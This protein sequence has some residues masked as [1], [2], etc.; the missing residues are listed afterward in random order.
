M[1]T[2]SLQDFK[3]LA[4]RCNVIPLSRET[5]VD[6]VTPVSVYERLSRGED[7]SYLLESVEGGERFGRYSFV[8]TRPHALFT[9]RE[10][11]L[12]FKEGPRSRSWT[13]SNPVQDMKKLFSQYRAPDL[14]ELPLF[15]GGAVGYW[16]YDTVRFFERLP[17]K[18][19]DILGFP[20]GAFQFS[21][22]L[23]IFDRL[24]QTAR[25]MTNVFIPEKRPS[26]QTLER[27]Y[28]EGLR[29][30][31]RQMKR[32]HD[33]SDPR[34]T[35]RPSK[36]GA[37]KPLGSRNDYETAVRKAKEYI[38]AGDIIQ[39]VLSQRWKIEPSAPPFEVYRALRTV[40]P[41][42]YMY[43]LH[44]PDFDIVGSSPEILVRKEGNQAVTRPIAGTRHRGASPE[45]DAGL[46]EELLKD[47]KERAEHL[48]L[49]DLGR[50]DLGRVCEPGSVR[51]PE[52]M[53]IE[54]YSH[55][56]HLV[57]SVSGRLRKDA[58]AFDL[59]QACF[60][61]GTLSG[62]PKIRAM[63]IIEE[64]EPDRRGPYGGAV[65]YFSYN[66]NMDMA[67]T[68]RTLVFR[69]KTAYMQA[70][71]GIVADSVPENEQRECEQKAAALFTAIQKT[72]EL[73]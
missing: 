32:I 31:D 25:V 36:I 45:E 17:R 47:P 1:T 42:P 66:G 68:I 48:M 9:C 15:W 34:A 18:N 51:V 52:L 54:N 22:D 37:P 41:S 71:A 14:P 6:R 23:V 58:N 57:S 61:A 12:T 73:S 7:H 21:G 39:V 38:R 49:V 44:F 26:Q 59:F 56:M 69:G 53:T 8:G 46:A 63:E 19:A 30:L 60:P 62:A 10:S 11:R 55:V 67:I 50:N 72:R 16:D 4:R 40:N 20:T 28:R 65:G 29:A 35:S 70:G 33:R 5:L 27:L 3:R 24:S 64:L 2:P 13:T 43:Y